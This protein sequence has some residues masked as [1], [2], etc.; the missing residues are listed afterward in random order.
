MSLGLIFLLGQGMAALPAL[1]DGTSVMLVAD[2]LRTIHATGLVQGDRLVIDRPLR[3][4]MVM[5][6]LV[7]PGGSG[8]IASGGSASIEVT[9][10]A[11]GTDLLVAGGESLSAWLVQN[12]SVQLF[13]PTQ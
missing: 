8:D 9:V 1:A 7:L 3:P 12:R 2:D 5:R 11:D 13:V 10:S 6:L 4:G